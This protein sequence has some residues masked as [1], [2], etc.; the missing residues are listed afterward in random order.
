MQDG[1]KSRRFLLDAS[2]A[3]LKR[4]QVEKTAIRWSLAWKPIGSLLFVPYAK[5]ETC[6][7]E[8]GPSMPQSP[9]RP[10]RRGFRTIMLYAGLFRS[11]RWYARRLVGMVGSEYRG[12]VLDLH[13]ISSNR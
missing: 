13:D 4:R 5:I 10:P 12:R 1:D 2:S 9:A 6:G 8:S 3:S 11:N 7:H